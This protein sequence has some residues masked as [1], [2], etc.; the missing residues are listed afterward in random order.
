[1]L[2][3]Y[4]TMLL[5]KVAKIEK[6]F[7]LWTAREMR[8]RRNI[9]DQASK[10]AAVILRPSSRTSS[11]PFSPHALDVSI[12][13]GTKSIPAGRSEYLAIF[14]SSAIFASEPAEILEAWMCEIAK[15][16][17]QVASHA[18][19][20]PF[21]QGTVVIPSGRFLVSP[22]LVHSSVGSRV[23]RMSALRNA[24]CI[25][26][27]IWLW[28]DCRPALFLHGRPWWPS[29]VTMVPQQHWCGWTKWYPIWDQLQFWLTNCPFSNRLMQLVLRPANHQTLQ[30]WMPII[31]LAR[32]VQ[33]FL[34]R[35]CQPDSDRWYHPSFAVL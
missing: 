28:R 14:F 25:M 6:A 2:F 32:Q 7:P 33:L 19:Q 26:P 1:M 21:F 34:T 23:A 8:W 13:I 5:L 18:R 30:T 9:A 22:A 31:W 3:L 15:V 4:S 17:G 24:W 12:A 35:D 27:L 10:F 29:D 20:R 11:N 16:S